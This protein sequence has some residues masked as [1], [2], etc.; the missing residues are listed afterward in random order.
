LK[1]S[2]KLKKVHTFGEYSKAEL[3]FDAA[4]LEAAIEFFESCKQPYYEGEL[5]NDK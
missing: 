5:K 4:Q 2:D 3:L 1:L